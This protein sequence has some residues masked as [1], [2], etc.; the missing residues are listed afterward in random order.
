VLYTLFFCISKKVEKF[1]LK[2]FMKNY[3]KKK[4]LS[5]SKIHHLLNYVG[6]KKEIP[7]ISFIFLGWA[8]LPPKFD[9]QFVTNIKL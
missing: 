5:K 8:N 1:V 3:K 9:L 7:R 4:N 6:R 2:G